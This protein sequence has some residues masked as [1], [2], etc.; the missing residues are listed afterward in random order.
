M[1]YLYKVNI[2]LAYLDSMLVHLENGYC[3]KAVSR[4]GPELGESAIFAPRAARYGTAS[5][6]NF[7]DSA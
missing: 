1:S 4:K 5:S 6:P 7:Q 2:D 3:D